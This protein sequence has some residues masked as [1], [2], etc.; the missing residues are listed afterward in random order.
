MSST[1]TVESLC[2]SE[3]S[4]VLPEKSTKRHLFRRYKK[5]IQPRRQLKL[6][7]FVVLFLLLYSLMFGIATYY[8]LGAELEKAAYLED[9]ARVA[10]VILG[11]EK[12]V[13]PALILVLVLAFIGTIFFS[14]RVVGPIY[15][16]ERA[17]QEIVRGNLKERI[18]L[19]KTDEFKE[20]ETMVNNLANYLEN[21]QTSDSCFRTDL[22]EKLST[23][24]SVLASDGKSNGEKARKIL[25]EVILKLDSQPD[26][27]TAY[28]K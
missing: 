28:K 4:T 24:A 26:A 11:L 6:A 18:R 23:V 22:R 15:C 19:R 20:I 5:I 12:T 8:P 16:L 1:H 3:C 14:H 13:W 2:Q 7:C 10:S 27:F 25:D 21:V 17:L 9:Q